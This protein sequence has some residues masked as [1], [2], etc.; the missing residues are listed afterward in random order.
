MAEATISTFV[1]LFVILLLSVLPVMVGAAVVGAERRGI[2]W[3]LV[4][5][6]VAGV[7]HGLGL[8]V[9][10]IGNVVAFVLAGVAFAWVLQTGIIKGLIIHLIQIVFWG[11]LG[12][13]ATV[14]FGVAL[15]G[16]L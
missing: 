10:G 12:A 9:P 11:V 14:L 8:T 13:L 2:L 5:T 6:V 7:L 4:A 16:S 1:I 15:L 3:S